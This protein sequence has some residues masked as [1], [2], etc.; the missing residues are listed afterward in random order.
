VSQLLLLLYFWLDNGANTCGIDFHFGNKT[1]K[2]RDLESIIMDD[3]PRR[4][5]Y[6]EFKILE[7]LCISDFKKVSE[8]GR[9]VDPQFDDEESLSGPQVLLAA[10]QEENLSQEREESVSLLNKHRDQQ[11]EVQVE[12]GVDQVEEPVEEVEEQV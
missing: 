3:A 11:M 6:F 12:V 9:W 10:E 4:E 7:E 5:T 1:V 2:K 8:E